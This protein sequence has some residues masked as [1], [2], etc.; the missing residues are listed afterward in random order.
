MQITINLQDEMSVNLKKIGQTLTVDPSA[1]PGNS[2]E[3][4]FAYG[5]R[6]LLN[7]SMSSHKAEDL[8][9]DKAKAAARKDADERLANLLAGTLRASRESDPIAAEARRMAGEIID[10]ALVRKYGNAKAVKGAGDA[11]DRA[12][13]VRDLLSGEHGPQLRADAKVVVD[14]K[15]GLGKVVINL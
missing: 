5:L 2:R 15:A 14:A 9:T 10:A 1:F 11:V 8:V 6:Q 12:A 7:D 13:L 3:H 4:I